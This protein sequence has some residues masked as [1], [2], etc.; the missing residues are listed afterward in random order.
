LQFFFNLTEEYAMFR[1]LLPIFSIVLL[2]LLPSYS[3]GGSQQYRQPTAEE[4]KGG[5]A[6]RQQITTSLHLPASANW[7]KIYRTL[8]DQTRITICEE[9]KKRGLK[10]SCDWDT[11]LITLIVT[12]DSEVRTQPSVD[13]ITALVAKKLISLKVFLS[14]Q[15]P[16]LDLQSS[17]E[18]LM[19]CSLQKDV[20]DRRR[21]L[22]F[23]P[24]T[25]TEL[26]NYVWGKEKGSEVV[27]PKRLPFPLPDLQGKKRM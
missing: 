3:F 24:D 21:Q 7:D 25:A 8:F 13:A 6:I 12:N 19:I 26:V 4:V 5:Q 22:N 18:D 14:T 2:L 11:I 15:C 1:R 17:W 10:D 23:A 9:F 27:D 20:S 16:L